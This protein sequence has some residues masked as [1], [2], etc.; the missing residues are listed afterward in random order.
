MLTRREHAAAE[1]AAKLRARGHDEAAVAAELERLDEAG[2]QSDHRFAE[3]YV[4]TRIDRGDGPLRLR[5]ALRERGVAPELIETVLAP[6]AEEW[7]ERARQLSAR[8]FGRAAAKSWAERARR[9]RYLQG[10]GYPGDIVRRVTDFEDH[11]D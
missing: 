10:R 2:L 7:T 1:L 11:V 9:A 6:H 8:R 3:S 4:A 5:A